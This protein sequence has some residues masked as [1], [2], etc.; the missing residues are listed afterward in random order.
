MG[1][2]R[3]EKTV[4]GAASASTQ[5]GH[6]MLCPYW[7]KGSPASLSQG[8]FALRSWARGPRSRDRRRGALSSNQRNSFTPPTTHGR[9]PPFPA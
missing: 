5:Y 2:P 1:Q 8:Y 4:R 9:K 3:K 7:A 6:S